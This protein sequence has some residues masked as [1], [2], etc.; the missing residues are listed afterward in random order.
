M[1]RKVPRMEKLSEVL[2]AAMSSSVEIMNRFGNAVREADLES[3]WYAKVGSAPKRK[4]KQR[5]T[6]EKSRRMNMRKR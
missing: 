2:R 4:K 6:A 3:P 1:E 5:K